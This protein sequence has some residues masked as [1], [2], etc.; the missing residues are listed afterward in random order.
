MKRWEFIGLLGCA[1]AGLSRPKVAK[2]PTK[3]PNF[4]FVIGGIDAADMA[5]PD[6]GFAPVRAFV[7]ELHDL[8]WIDGR[9]VA[10][11]RCTLEGNPKRA[12]HIR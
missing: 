11:E 4:N 12:Y 2:Q 8:G 6:P 10:I 7:Q 1:A 9:T 3:Q 5:G